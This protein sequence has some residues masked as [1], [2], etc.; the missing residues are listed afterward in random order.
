F[1]EN[2][3]F[4][5]TKRPQFALYRGRRSFSAPT[6]AGKLACGAGPYCSTEQ[7]IQIVQVIQERRQSVAR[8]PAWVHRPPRG[9]CF[10]GS[11]TFCAP[12]PAVG[13]L[14]PARWPGLRFGFP[15]APEHPSGPRD[16]APPFFVKGSFH[17]THTEVRQPTRRWFSPGILPDY[18]RN[19]GGS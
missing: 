13:V 14:E 19:T 2:P 12:P 3:S 9:R 11:G 6:V 5:V 18:G 10:R 8:V 4:D 15:T 16:F 17:E 7:P 1:Q